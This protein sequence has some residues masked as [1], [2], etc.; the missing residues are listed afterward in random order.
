MPFVPKHEARISLDQY[1]G[2]A[3]DIMAVNTPVADGFMRVSDLRKDIV[4]VKKPEQR[5]ADYDQIGD[6]KVG[7]LLRVPR[8]HRGQTT[9]GLS[10]D[11]DAWYIELDDQAIAR[12]A[13]EKTSPTQKFDELFTK[14]F[15]GEVNERIKEILLRE[16]VVGQG[17]SFLLGS[18][19]YCLA[20]ALPTGVGVSFIE[21]PQLMQNPE[22]VLGIAF[23]A[24]QFNMIANFAGMAGN[25][26]R[27]VLS[28]QLG[29][30]DSSVLTHTF[31]R[32]NIFELPLP[33]IPVDR[34]IR[35]RAY[36]AMHGD[37]IIQSEKPTA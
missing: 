12:K 27:E 36:I 2:I 31:H 11:S 6:V 9:S 23:A 25:K 19:N 21:H 30:E 8:L 22:A 14:Q 5:V 29:D 32:R 20:V 1:G 35:G 18:F 3:S 28:R 7:K 4:I 16:K 17:Y 13:S 37:K 34:A 10:H 15:K 26:F 33:M 24:F